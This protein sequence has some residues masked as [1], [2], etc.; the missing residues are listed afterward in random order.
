LVKAD[1]KSQALENSMSNRPIH[2]QKLRLS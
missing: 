1:I 2:M